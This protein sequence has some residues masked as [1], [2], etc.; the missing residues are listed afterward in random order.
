MTYSSIK[1]APKV[2]EIYGAECKDVRIN[3]VIVKTYFFFCLYPLLTS[4]LNM[5]AYIAV[6]TNPAFDG[7]ICHVR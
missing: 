7:H 3:Y 2:K 1:E 6:Q 4:K 5:F